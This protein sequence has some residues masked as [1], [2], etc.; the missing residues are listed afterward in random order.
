MSDKCPICESLVS[1]VSAERVEIKAG[2]ISY[3]GISFACLVCHSILSVQMDPWALK[4]ELVAELK[5]ALRD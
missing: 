4:N 1:E 5:T 2:E 3:R